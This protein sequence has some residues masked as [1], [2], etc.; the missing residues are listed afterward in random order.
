MA[1]PATDSPLSRMTRFG[2]RARNFAVLR[3]AVRKLVWLDATNEPG[4]ATFG[5]IR[6]RSRARPSVEQVV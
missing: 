5:L 1:G 6:S 4:L 3:G 2:S